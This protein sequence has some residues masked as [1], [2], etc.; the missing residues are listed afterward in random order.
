[1]IGALV[2]LERRCIV[3]DPVDLV[4]QDQSFPLWIDTNIELSASG[5][6]LHGPARILMGDC[7]EALPIG[8]IHLEC[9]N[10]DKHKIS[11]RKCFVSVTNGF[12][13]E[14]VRLTRSAA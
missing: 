2:L 10:D 12:K 13:F 7:Q 1:V 14:G 4:E 6:T 9:C 3:V 5:L 11:P 8:R